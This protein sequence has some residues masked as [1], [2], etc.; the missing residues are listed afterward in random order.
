MAILK[1]Y[2]VAVTVLFSLSI[3]AYSQEEIQGQINDQENYPIAYAQ[4]CNVKSN[5]CTYTNEEGEFSLLA[6]INDSL[7]VSCLGYK[8]DH[9][10]TSS[11][12]PIITL[13]EDALELE[14]VVIQSKDTLEN[15]SSDT[16]K[17]GFNLTSISTKEL[18]NT[19]EN[20][21][22][23]IKK[24]PGINIREAGGLGSGFELSLNGLSGNQIR[25]FIDGVPMENFG[26]SLTLNNYPVNLIEKIEIY[27]GALPVSLGADALGGAIN[28]VTSNQL[29][30]YIDASYSLGSFNTHILSLNGMVSDTSKGVYLKLSSFYNH[31]DNNYKMY[32]VPV[33]DLELGNS[34]GTVDIERFHDQYTSRMLSL[35]AGI[36]DKK[37]ADKLALK[38]T[39]AGN[40]KNYQHP[41]NNILRVMGG[42]STANQTTLASFDYRKKVLGRLKIM[43][44]GTLGNINENVIDT[45]SL[46]YNWS[47]DFIQRDVA[48]ASGEFYQRK[49]D[50]HLNDKILRTQ[51]RAN[52]DINPIS[53]LDISW[54]E[55]FLRRSGKD[56]VDNFNNS[57][58][59]PN[60]INKRVLGLAYNLNNRKRTL[61]GSAFVKNYYYK[62]LIITEDYEQN[63]IIT[64][65]EVKKC[66]YGATLSY[67]KSE[68][69]VFKTSFEQAVRMPEPY[70]ILGDGI[71]IRPNAELQ[72]EN[73]LNLNFGATVK[74]PI[75][76][77]LNFYSEANLFVRQSQDFIRFNAVGIFGEYENLRNV[78]SQGV[79]L[80]TSIEYKKIFQLSLNGTFQ[81]LTDQTEFE[82][83][84]VNFNYKS[85][86]PNIPYLFSNAQISFKPKLKN[87]TR[88]L[89]FSW[90]TSYTHEFFLLWGNLG[91]ASQK[92][93]I[94]SQFVNGI[95]TEYSI[96]N[97]KYNC[98][99]TVNNIFNELVYDNIN[100]Q[101]PGRSIMFKI[102]AFLQLKN[103]TKPLNN[104]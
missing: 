39:H 55:N 65:P 84:L 16:D 13:L 82:D 32:D 46:K 94:P 102:R 31:S 53:S 80:A 50:F 35:E 90:N 47:G 59:T 88:N 29:D 3:S 34:L 12:N 77:N 1:K 57:F 83:G 48:D 30:N 17:S 92:Y 64:E 100:I 66:G 95:Q 33:Y 101:K 70:E 68:H 69:L 62:G 97:G 45:S 49:S 11:L 26:S 51:L 38:F 78:K 10:K 74:F 18:K 81:E 23:I 7:K 28:I 24:T 15:T 87:E 41:D 86:L 5:N 60:N 99:V 79:E 25:Y 20:I 14:E 75:K 93:I 71:Y 104:N 8:I 36:V 19:S 27:K 44:Y 72:P 89:R 85:Q 96:K 73:S 6:E 52:Y 56:K 61:R 22:Q 43:A 54:S 42:F 21:N 98:S 63:E 91:L 58:V 103:L 37:L 40:D 67:S 2:I 9:F 4:V 76:N